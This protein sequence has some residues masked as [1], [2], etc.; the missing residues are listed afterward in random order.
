MSVCWQLDLV[1]ESAQLRQDVDVMA[2]QFVRAM[3]EAAAAAAVGRNSTSGSDELPG[4]AKRDATMKKPPRRN[5]PRSRPDGN[6]ASRD[7]STHERPHGTSPGGDGNDTFRDDD[8]KENVFDRSRCTAARSDG[9]ASPRPLVT[10][11]SLS[12][13]AARSGSELVYWQCLGSVIASY[14][15]PRRRDDEH[16]VARSRRHARRRFFDTPTSPADETP[17]VARPPRDD[18]RT[19]DDDDTNTSVWL[20]DSSLPDVA[21]SSGVETATSSPPEAPPDTVVTEQVRTVYSYSR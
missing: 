9:L 16:G 19:D 20:S 11:A 21:S 10:R 2:S 8:N 17:V 3:P 12:P 4:A 1:A 18:H 6:C 7:V 15:S 14:L 5:R 13:A